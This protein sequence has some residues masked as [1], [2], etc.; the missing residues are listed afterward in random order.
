[1]EREKKEEVDF[2]RGQKTGMSTDRNCETITVKVD[3]N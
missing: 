3:S 2:D 1:L